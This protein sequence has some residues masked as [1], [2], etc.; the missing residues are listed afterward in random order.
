MESVSDDGR[1]RDAAGHRDILVD[2]RMGCVFTRSG[3]GWVIFLF[4]VGGCMRCNMG[5]VVNSK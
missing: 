2:D 3:G 1:K 5:R 4:S